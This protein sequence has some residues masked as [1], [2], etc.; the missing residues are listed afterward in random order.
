ME[1]APYPLLFLLL[2]LNNLQHGQAILA[3]YGIALVFRR[4]LALSL[5]TIH[6]QR[7][8]CLELQAQES[9]A[10]SQRTVRHTLNNKPVAA[11]VAYL[12]HTVGLPPKPQACTLAQRRH[13]HYPLCEEV[14]LPSILLI[15]P[16]AELFPAAPP[17]I[18]GKHIKG[19]VRH[20][21]V[22][23]GGVAPHA[24]QCG[25]GDVFAQNG[26]YS[27]GQCNKVHMGQQ[28]ATQLAFH[29]LAQC[30]YLRNICLYTHI[31]CKSNCFFGKIA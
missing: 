1:K 15:K 25:G 14:R 11:Q 17:G 12:A 31:D 9:I 3:S 21:V 13:R 30:S 22:V 19:A 29:L 27:I 5:E 26:F 7:L 23:T 8:S 18:A 6:I 2:L 28:L 20:G 24:L 4:H 10:H 16:L